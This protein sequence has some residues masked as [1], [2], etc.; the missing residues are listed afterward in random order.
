MSNL[1]H[2]LSTISKSKVIDLSKT[3]RARARL[4]EEIEERAL[5]AGAVGQ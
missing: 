1:S 5:D 4:A 2:K 3:G